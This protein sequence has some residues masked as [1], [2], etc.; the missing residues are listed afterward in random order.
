MPLGAE[1]GRWKNWSRGNLRGATRNVE[2]E[3]WFVDETFVWRLSTWIKFTRK[4]VQMG[5]EHQQEVE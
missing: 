2:H 5:Y 1:K 4:R 3:T